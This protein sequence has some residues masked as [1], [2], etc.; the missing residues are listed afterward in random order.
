MAINKNVETHKAIINN[1][2]NFLDITD[3]YPKSLEE[4][5]VVISQI[6]YEMTTSYIK[7]TK[8]ACKAI[9]Q[10]S[11]YVELFD[12]RYNL[13]LDKLGIAT[14]EQLPLNK[15]SKEDDK[16]DMIYK[17]ALDV[18]SYDVFPIF[19][20][21]EHTI[22]NPI[23]KALLEKEQDKF[24][25]ISFDAHSDL[26]HSYEDNTNSHACVMRRIHQDLEVPIA[27]IGIRAQCKDE[28]DYIKLNNINVLYAHQI[29][30][31]SG[32]WIK[33]MLRDLP[34]KVYISFD[35]DALDPIIMMATGTIEPNGLTYKQAMDFIEI[36]ASH[37]QIIGMDFVEHSPI[38]EERYSYI[39]AKFIANSIAT[40]ANCGTLLPNN[41]IV[42]NIAANT[43]LTSTVPSI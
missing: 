26:R 13:E 16:L 24:A 31:D 34:Q 8:N 15:V 43:I 5:K 29:N 19:V 7:G 39:A 30:K 23:I 10:N 35:F 3:N 32:N 40:I 42:D 2:N 1:K 9:I 37:S 27:E 25:V 11:A 22:T 12:E 38:A 28:Y 6:P 17:H 36:I 33:K 41:G 4:A 21:G 14:L 18:L 20:G